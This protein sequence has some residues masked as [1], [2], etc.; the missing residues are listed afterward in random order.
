MLD[1]LLRYATPR[2]FVIAALMA[3]GAA[4]AVRLARYSYW[5]YQKA[6]YPPVRAAAE[7]GADIKRFLDK[8][9]SEKIEG[10]YRRVG[11][12]ILQAKADGFDV[13]ALEDRAN[14]ALA[15]NIPGRRDVAVQI[16]NEVELGVPKKKV[17]YL[18]VYNRVDENN[19]SDEEDTPKARPSPPA[20][21][22]TEAKKAPS[23]TAK[24]GARRR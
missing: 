22:A 4:P 16:L 6:L 1:F 21:A 24:K 12:L 7:E 5:R 3:A 9:E 18:P 2:N 20:K 14:E 19:M 17:Q 13:A 10:R 8:R 15:Y 11:A 23:K